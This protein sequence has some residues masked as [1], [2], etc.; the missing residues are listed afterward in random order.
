VS[1]NAEKESDNIHNEERELMLAELT[2]S[3][4][5]WTLETIIG[6]FYTFLF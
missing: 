4:Y 1:C 2:Y 6:S 3:R 5:S